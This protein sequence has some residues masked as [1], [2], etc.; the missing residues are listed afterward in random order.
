MTVLRHCES[1]FSERVWEW[2]EIRL[3]GAILAPGKW[4]VISALRMMGLSQERQFQNFHR[5]W[6]R[7]T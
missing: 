7:A 3:V 6:N 4:T 1:M 2:A 5:M